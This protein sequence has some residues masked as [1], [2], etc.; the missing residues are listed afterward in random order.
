MKHSILILFS[1]LV[2]MSCDNADDAQSQNDPIQLILSELETTELNQQQ[3]EYNNFFDTTGRPTSTDVTV[4]LLNNTQ[5][6][7]ESIN[8]NADN[9]I[10]QFIK[11]NNGFEPQE[12]NFNYAN[13][14][15][16]SINEIASGPGARTFQFS[17]NGNSIEV[18]ISDVGPIFQA[19]LTYNFSNTSYQQ[20]MSY[21]RVQPYVDE[22]SNPD[23]RFEYN[24]DQNGNISQ[25]TKYLFDDDTS[26][27]EIAYIET[28]SYDD[29]VNPFRLFF[30][31]NPLIV[32]NLEVLEPYSFSVFRNANNYATHNIT[33]R[34][35]T[36]QNIA[37]ERTTNY[38]YVY[39]E[40]DHPISSSVTTTDIDTDTNEQS[41]GLMKSVTYNYY[42]Q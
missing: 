31:A 28:I 41:D 20:L 17:Y 16:E 38:T 24:Y 34:T 19:K 12:Y 33:N 5:T 1:L 7:E 27:L 10:D 29:K 14:S 23:Y 21:E 2:V 36:Y 26:Q 39:D 32:M 37:L 18:L 35:R 9:T 25:I 22:N 4:I 6:D 42:E 8:Y 40:F 3:R 30:D 15:L 13:N 11:N